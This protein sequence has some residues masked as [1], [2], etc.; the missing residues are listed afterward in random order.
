MLPSSVSSQS[1]RSAAARRRRDGIA[2]DT[3]RTTVGST[4]SATNSSAGTAGSVTSAASSA[5]GPVYSRTTTCALVPPKPKPDTPAT[6]VPRVARPVRALGNDLQVRLVERDVRVGSGEVQRRRQVVFLHRQ[7]D[8]DQ[9]R[10]ACGC[11]E[12]TE[13]GLGRA[14]QRGLVVGASTPDDASERIRLDRVAE[15][16]A[17][18]VRLDVVDAG[19]VDARVAVGVAQDVG[20]R[21]RVRRREA[22]GA[23]VLVDRAAG[24]HGEDLVAVPLG[25]LETLQDHETAALGANHAVGVGGER[26]DVAVWRPSHRAGRSPAWRAARAS[27]FT[28]PASARS[29][30]PDRRRAHRLVHRDQRRRARGVEGDRRPA[31]VVEVGNPVGDDRRRR[32]GQR[33]RVRVVGVG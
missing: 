3:A 27:M 5:A 10:G 19:R 9:A 23:A 26:L 17:G 1:A 24:D 22:V 11:L 16:G 33:I 21:I 14:E 13:V 4:A 20:L 6:A 7:H 12:V 31:E 28:P 25:V 18:A 32:T 15:D 2:P 29:D 8:L 30:S